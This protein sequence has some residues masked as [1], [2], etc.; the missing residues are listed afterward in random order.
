MD[1]SRVSIEK[2]LF[3]SSIPFSFEFII[4]SLN[5]NT[6][7]MYDMRARVR[8]GWGVGNNKRKHNIIQ[9]RVVE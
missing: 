8:V 5:L 2:K 3:Q 1:S 9:M 7:Y 4:S 6:I